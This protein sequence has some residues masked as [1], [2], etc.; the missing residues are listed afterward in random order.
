MAT[1]ASML[2]R[3]IVS[4]TVHRVFTPNYDFWRAR[5]SPVEVRTI[6]VHFSASD[7]PPPVLNAIWQT[8]KKFDWKALN[9]LLD[10]PSKR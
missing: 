2:D 5:K 6:A 8:Y 3:D 7:A 10:Q 4:Q 1:G 9:A